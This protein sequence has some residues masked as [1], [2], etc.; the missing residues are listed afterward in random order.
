MGYRAV[1]SHL[2]S[3]ERLGLRDSP[4]RAPRRKPN[5][6]IAIA[7]LSIAWIV[8]ELAMSWYRDHPHGD[9]DPGGQ[10]LALLAHVARQ[11][12]APG[13]TAAHLDLKESHWDPGGCDGGAPGWSRME[14]VQIFRAPGDVAS[15]VD[16]AMREQR[17]HSVSI[18]GGRSVR[19]YK[20]VENTAYGGYGW[21]FAET[22]A[23][24]TTWH[25]ILSAAPAEI[26]THA[27]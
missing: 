2:A 11:A 7:L 17:W 14:A 16:A 18:Q 3:G 19:E 27:C 1:V 5:I 26:P 12:V 21:L 8:I 15:Q 4:D 6:W 20:P 23:A 22:G 13:A 24:G 9:P 25:L 10:R